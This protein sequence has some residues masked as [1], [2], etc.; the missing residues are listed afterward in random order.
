MHVA[1]VC[2]FSWSLQLSIILVS[3][4]TI[5]KCYM[6]LQLSTT[7]PCP[8]PSPR[9][10]SNSYA[11]SQWCHPTTSSSV[12]SFSSCLQSFPASGSCLVSWLFT[13]GGQSIGASALVSAFPVNIQDWFPLGWTGLWFDL[14][15]VQETLKSR[16]QHHSPKASILQFSAFFMVL[17]KMVE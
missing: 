4:Q 11:S 5:K 15:A 14:L 3:V 10:C 12:F 7:F 2:A 8:S 6:Y 1:R 13:S 17:V 9:A 16:L